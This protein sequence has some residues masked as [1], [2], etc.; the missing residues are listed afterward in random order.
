MSSIVCPAANNIR[1]EV[2]QKFFFFYLWK[3]KKIKIKKI[4]NK[5][6][7][8]NLLSGAGRNTH[9]HADLKK[10]SCSNNFFFLAAFLLIVQADLSEYFPFVSMSYNMSM[11][12]P[13]IYTYC[14]N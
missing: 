3:K 12:C 2:L 14:I 8:N 9:F 10:K 4:R 13:D 11:F 7:G 6:A 1:K 5:R